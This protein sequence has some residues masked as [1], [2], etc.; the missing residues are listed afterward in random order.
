MCNKFPTAMS[1]LLWFRFW[2]VFLH[3]VLICWYF[4]YCR[5]VLQFLIQIML[6]SRKAFYRSAL[7]LTEIFGFWFQNPLHGNSNSN[8]SKAEISSMQL[9]MNKSHIWF[10][11]RWF[12]FGRFYW[13][14]KKKATLEPYNS[15]NKSCRYFCNYKKSDVINMN[16]TER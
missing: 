2:C 10:S 11:F 14:L 6:V 7:L 5:I 9:N 3:A 13:N 4:N 1:C 12:S 15:T 8:S 16:I